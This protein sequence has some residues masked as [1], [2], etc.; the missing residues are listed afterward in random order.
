MT[1]K[2]NVWKGRE[3][4]RVLSKNKTW[5]I[6]YETTSF[7]VDRNVIQAD[8]PSGKMIVVGEY[9]T[10][11]EAQKMLSSLHRAGSVLKPDFRL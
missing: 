4:M 5:T 1:M 8:L 3:K 7:K 6:P 10:E 9:E 2:L 11:D